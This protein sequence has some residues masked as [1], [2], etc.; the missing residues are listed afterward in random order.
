VVSSAKNNQ[1]VSYKYIIVHALSRRKICWIYINLSSLNSFQ[2][3]VVAYK[4]TSPL[5]HKNDENEV[6]DWNSEYRKSGDLKTVDGLRHETFSQA[7]MTSYILHTHEKDHYGDDELSHWGGPL[8][9]DDAVHI[10]HLL[11]LFIAV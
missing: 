2:S 11:L 10:H 7:Y 1:N 8:V 4:V 3:V 5:Y 6:K 9:A